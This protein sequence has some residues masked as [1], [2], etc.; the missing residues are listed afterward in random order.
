MLVISTFSDESIANAVVDGNA[1]M[2]GKTSRNNILY[3]ETADKTSGDDWV[4]AKNRSWGN[5][6]E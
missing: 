4:D 3:D 6:W 1:T 2:V 5:L